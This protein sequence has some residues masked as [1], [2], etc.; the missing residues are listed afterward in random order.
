LAGPADPPPASHRAEQVLADHLLADP[1]HLGDLG[2]RLALEEVEVD[3]LPLLLRQAR[4]DDRADLSD[5]LAH[6][7]LTSPAALVT[8]H[9]PAQTGRP[10]WPGA[11]SADR[12]GRVHR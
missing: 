3:H 8:A 9:R 1:E 7:A 5:G 2:L 6:P 10:R 11:D 12:R 4:L